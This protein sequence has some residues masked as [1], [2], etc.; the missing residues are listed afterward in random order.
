MKYTEL[1]DTRCAIA[2]GL[3]VVGEWWTLLIV[4][5]IVGGLHRFDELHAELGLSRRILSERLSALVEHGVLVRRL[6]CERPPRYEYHLTPMGQGLLPVLVS[7]QDWASRYVLGDGSLTATTRPRSIEA[8]RMRH[9][10]GTRIPGMTLLD[11]TGTPRDPVSGRDWTVLYCFPGAYAHPAG[12]PADWGAI[13]GAPGCTLESATYRDRIS[14]FTAR[15]AQVYG[16]STQRTEDQTAFAAR[17]RLPFPLLSDQEFR[18]A[19]G[20]RLPT[21]RAA[22]RSWLKRGT[23]LVRSDREIRGVL[24][25][26]PDPAASV[27]HALAVLDSQRT[28]TSRRRA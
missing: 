26:V 4:R 10:I 20:L 19:T 27:D 9:L 24:Y 25:P 14:E 15:G 17:Q 23:L 2:Q 1:S 22:G 13:P 7:L 8:Q 6:Y 16:V 21:F 12:Y 28:A 5:D 18:L 3:G 11:S